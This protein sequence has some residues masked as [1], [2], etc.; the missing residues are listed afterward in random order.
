M[1]WRWIVQA[2]TVCCPSVGDWGLPSLCPC[3][4]FCMWGDYTWPLISQIWCCGSCHGWRPALSSLPLL[5]HSSFGKSTVSSWGLKESVGQKA[6]HST[7]EPHLWA[8]LTQT[9]VS[10]R[11]EVFQRWSTTF[12]VTLSP[13][14]LRIWT[15]ACRS[16]PRRWLDWVCKLSCPG[17][18]SVAWRSLLLFS[19]PVMS[20]S[21]WPSGWQHARLPCFFTVS[22]SLLK[23]LFIESIMPSN[24]LILC[25]LLLLLPSIFPTIRIF[26]NESALHSRWPKYWGFS[27]SISPSNEYSGLISFRTDWFDLLEIKLHEIKLLKIKFYEKEFPYTGYSLT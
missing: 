10:Q 14:A 26:S 11:T 13:T 21:L 7:Q 19:R 12:C 1:P 27:F 17:I 15:A 16:S 9:H 6:K 3:V 2:D 23:L 24:H 25:C 4:M 22:Q 5:S 18:P 8:G 20:D